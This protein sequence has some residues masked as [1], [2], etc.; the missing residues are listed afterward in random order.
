MEVSH[1]VIQIRL[2]DLGVS[3]EDVHDKGA[4]INGVEIFGRVVKNSIVDIV[5]HH[6]KLVVRD[7]ED[8]FVC[9]PCLPCG[10]ISGMQFLAF[11]CCGTGWDDWVGWRFNLWD[12]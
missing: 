8:Q 2:A 5:N 1:V 12:V 3:G 7:G 6:R 11:G 9:V 10:G 4:E